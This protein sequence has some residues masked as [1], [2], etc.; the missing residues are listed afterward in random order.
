[1]VIDLAPHQSGLLAHDLADA[2]ARA[3]ALVGQDR[4]R[5]FE[6]MREIADVRPCPRENQRRMLEEPVE[7]AGQGCDFAR[8]FAIETLGAAIPDR[9][10]RR[11]NPL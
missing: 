5:R 4:E 9:R 10:Q 8:K 7:F 1:M 2:A 11:P 3:I 6:R